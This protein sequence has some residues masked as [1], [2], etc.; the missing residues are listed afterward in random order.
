M[1]ELYEETIREEFPFYEAHPPCKTDYE[2]LK[3]EL[4]LYCTKYN[5]KTT[6]YYK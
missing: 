4:F 2:W 5:I 3:I 1:E 6:I